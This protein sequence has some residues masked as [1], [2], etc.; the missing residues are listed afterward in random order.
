V[1]LVLSVQGGGYFGGDRLEKFVELLWNQSAHFAMG[2]S[3]TENDVDLPSGSFTSHLAS[4]RTDIA[5]NSNWSWSNFF[6]Y[7]NTGDVYGLNSRLRYVPEA[8]QEVVLV[9]NH[10][11][12]V[13][14]ANRLSS[15]QSAINLK[16]SYTFRY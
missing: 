9:L 2:F 10:G 7:D 5:F 8:G 14:P 15:T 3:I 4:F 11:G 12:V 1:R 6:Q 13:D 16:V